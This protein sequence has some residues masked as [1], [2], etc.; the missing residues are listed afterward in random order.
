MG[1]GIPLKVPTGNLRKLLPSPQAWKEQGEL[2]S[3]RKEGPGGLIGA[4]AETPVPALL[5]T[6]LGKKSC[7]LSLLR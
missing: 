7:R 4:G 3:V 6:G 1:L 5:G 2:V